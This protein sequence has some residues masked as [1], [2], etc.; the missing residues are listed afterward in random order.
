M[1]QDFL[2]AKKWFSLL[3]SMFYY[4]S[5]D[6]IIEAEFKEFQPRLNL[7]RGSKMLIP[8]KIV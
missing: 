3:Q 2:K 6:N 8:L 7:S 5:H 1:E 4:L